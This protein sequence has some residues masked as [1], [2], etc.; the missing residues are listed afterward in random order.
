MNMA[1]RLML[2]LFSR[3]FFL[4]GFIL[5]VLTGFSP[6]Q[7]QAEPIQELNPERAKF[8][9]QLSC[10]GCHAPDGAGG[11]GVPALNGH[12]GHFLKSQAGRE[13]LIRV[14]GSANALLSDE[15]LAEVLNWMILEFAQGSSPAQWQAYGAAE[16]G[17]YRADPLLEVLNYRQALLE[18]IGL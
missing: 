1:I 18:E 16:V 4:A 13:Y 11:T 10:Q 15:H 17:D 14:P 6:V 2:V 3:G 7:A 8:N 5:T 9:Y 12:I